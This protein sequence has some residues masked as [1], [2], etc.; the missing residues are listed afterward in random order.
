MVSF[1]MT[2]LYLLP[3]RILCVD[4]DSSTIKCYEEFL[5]HT[6]YKFQ[7]ATSVEDGL[8]EAKKNAPDIIL[9]NA[10]L[11]GLNGVEF[12]RKIKNDNRL[13]KCMFILVSTDRIEPEDILSSE[14]E[15]CADDFLIKP[16]KEKEFLLKIKS[17]LKIKNLKD[18]LAGSN[19]KLNNALNELSW[20]KNEVEVKNS[21]LLNQKNILEHSLKQISLMVEER[22]STSKELELIKKHHKNDIKN[23][24][25]LLSAI[26]E[27]KMHNHRGHAR[28]IS[29]IATFITKELDLPEEEIHD[30]KIASL[31][32]ES[33]KLFFP[34]DLAKKDPQTY[35]QAE[36][37]LHLY[38]PCKG[39]SMLADF[40][41]FEKVSK[42]IRHF[43]ENIDGSGFPD[44]LKGDDIPVGSRIIAVADYFDN[45]ASMD[46]EGSVEK[47]FETVEENI[48]AGFDAQIV[49]YLRKYL[50]AGLINGSY[51]IREVSIYGLESGMQLASGIY[52]ESNAKLLPKDTV[53][54]EDSIN[55]VAQYNK[56]DPLKETVFIK[57]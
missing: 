41:C 23:L 55:R 27:A 32:H 25:I 57:K 33:G 37:D 48:G 50:N 5:R 51:R 31:L 28:K 11:P 13:S 4:D 16:F 20:Y 10:L 30:I 46:A 56:T 14:N 3:N 38:H 36:K 19:T 52:T 9:S 47:A 43:H 26:I 17:N 39:A 29:E 2:D 21:S 54:T 53:L 44:G 42:I 6:D 49:H 7:T 35:S 12:C 24:I 45:L 22:E 1:A 34:D 40:S 8:E 18:E 15:T